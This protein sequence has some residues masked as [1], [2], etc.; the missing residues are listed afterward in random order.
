MV[1]QIMR[2]AA[3]TGVQGWGAERRPNDTSRGEGLIETTL[4]QFTMT[5]RGAR[6]H[7]CFRFICITR[8]A[9]LA[10]RLQSLPVTQ[11]SEGQ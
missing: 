2:S 7:K 3:G 5:I 6:S 8:T 9:G 11:G 1:P 4:R 10:Y